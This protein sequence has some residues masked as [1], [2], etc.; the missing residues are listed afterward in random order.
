MMMD[1]IQLDEE[2]LQSRGNRVT[3]SF[4]YQLAEE[5]LKM[6]LYLPIDSLPIL[7][8]HGFYLCKQAWL[9][10]TPIFQDSLLPL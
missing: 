4:P 5:M 3:P 10:W 1:K 9:I 6:Y 8:P 7:A 2:R